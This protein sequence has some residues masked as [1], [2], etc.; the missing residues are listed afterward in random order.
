[1][2]DEIFGPVVCISRFRDERDVLSRANDTRYGLA[3]AVHTRD[4]ERAVRVTNALKA[5]T[6]WVNMYN[7]VHH[8]IPF[9][10]Y[11]ESGIGRECGEAALEN[12]TETK[13]V[14]W[15]LGLGCPK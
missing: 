10:G 2:R 4:L 11:K 15:N 5:G 3:A 7:F 6:A 9:G 1:M 14:F 8:S 13:A 12:Y